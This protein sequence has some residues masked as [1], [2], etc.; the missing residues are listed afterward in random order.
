MSLGGDPEGTYLGGREGVWEEKSV[1]ERGIYTN[2]NKRCG[3]V[4]FSGKT[5]CET[6]FAIQ[7]E[8]QV[9]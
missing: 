6:F 5:L 8:I 3:F 9:R 2:N 4:S 1:G 7:M